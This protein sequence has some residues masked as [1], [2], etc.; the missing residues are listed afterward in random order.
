LY[1][2]PSTELIRYLSSTRPPAPG[3]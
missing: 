3:S 2:P 1:Q